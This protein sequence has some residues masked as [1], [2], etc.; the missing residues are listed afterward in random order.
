MNY[1][2]AEQV[3][4]LH[5]RIT[6][7]TG[8]SHGMVRLA[9]LESAIGR[10]MATFGGRELYGDLFTKAAILMNSLVRN[11]PFIDGNKRTAV[12]AAALLVRR[13]GFR[14]VM[15]SAE[16]EDLALAAAVG[17]LTVADMANGLRTG[18]MLEG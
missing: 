4:F 1:L 13:N 9:L 15:S 7:E 6:S 3:L 18:S 11:H 2:T 16:L 17:S 12:A 8:G 14:V 10:P 5:S